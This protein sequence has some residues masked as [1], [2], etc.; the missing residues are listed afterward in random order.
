MDNKKKLSEILKQL[1]LL[2]KDQLR[3]AHSHGVPQYILL[4]GNRFI[5]VHLNG[6]RHLIIDFEYNDWYIGTVKYPNGD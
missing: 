6:V 2:Q 1:E 5:G 3:L 4:P